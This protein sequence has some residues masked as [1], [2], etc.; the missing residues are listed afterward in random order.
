MPAMQSPTRPSQE[1]YEYTVYDSPSARPIY[2]D[3]AYPVLVIMNC[4][5]GFEWNEDL[6]IHT[7]QRG[8]GKRHKSYTRQQREQKIGQ[9]AT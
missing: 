1:D 4:H 3:Y 8:Q 9:V 5:E 2:Q 7:F 6:F